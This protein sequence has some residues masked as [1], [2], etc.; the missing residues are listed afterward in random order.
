MV[1]ER[2][3]R[4]VMDDARAVAESRSRDA[5]VEVRDDGRA[6]TGRSNAREGGWVFF[7]ARDGGPH[8][9][10]TAPREDAIA[11]AALSPAD[12]E[13]TFLRLS[14]VFRRIARDG[15]RGEAHGKR[16][17]AFRHA[18][19]RAGQFRGNGMDFGTGRARYPRARR[20]RGA[21]RGADDDKH[22]SVP[23]DR[24]VTNKLVNLVKPRLR[25][26]ARR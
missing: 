3:D 1:I 25:R 11:G 15:G 10:V 26:A 21:R 14:R 22:L 17:D 13:R 2:C 19:A 9:R 16:A 18:W 20:E 12:I 7:C 5:G 8:A 4:A 6:R 24:T 23:S